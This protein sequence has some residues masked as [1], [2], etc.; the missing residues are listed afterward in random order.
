MVACLVDEIVHFRTVVGYLPMCVY[1]VMELAALRRSRCVPE[2]S[3]Y[4]TF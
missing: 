2:A 3:L 4:N 1:P